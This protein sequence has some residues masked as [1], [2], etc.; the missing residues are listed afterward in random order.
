MVHPILMPKPGQMTEECTLV[1]WHKQVGDEVHKG[2]ILFEIETDK[3]NM[4]VEAFD[5]GILLRIDV[6]AGETV[7]VNTVCA[8]VGGPGESLPELAD[9]A[10]AAVAEVPATPGVAERPERPARPAPSTAAATRGSLAAAPS[11]RS[12]SPRASRIAA[13]AGID[14][15]TVTGSGPDG[16]IVERDVQAAIDA[17]EASRAAEVSRAAQ[18]PSPGPAVPNAADADDVSQTDD[19][20]PTDDV[21]Q[22]DDVPTP[23]SRMRQ[24]I[25]ER[26]TRS[27]TTIPHFSMTVGV[28]MT[29]LL[30]LRQDLK[31]AGTSLSITDFILM[32]TA[33]TLAEF[34]EANSR[35][36]GTSVWLRRRVHLGLAVSIPNGLVVPVLRDADRLTLHE[37]HDRAAG[38]A[39]AARNG[40]LSP[41]EM[42]GGTFTISNLGMLGVD[43]FEAII[44]PGEAAI[45]AVSSVLSTPVA[46]GDGI[47]LRQIMK[48]TLSADHRL[49]DGELAA[50]F[51]N[52]LR[53]RLQDVEA[54]RGEALQG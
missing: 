46:F 3:S 31:Q 50:R 30:A 47:A 48:L 52:A 32:A 39:E 49:I 10:P 54:M 37:L 2:D 29:R 7:P 40:T 38:L 45:L 4:D 23:L 21:P 43:Q 8:Y 17:A 1:S 12:I 22:T 5:D 28:D 9:R 24:V 11:G 42:R 13:M 35:T 15:R 34:P 6:R 33:Q 18:A 16:R 20:P 14:P 41:D 25:A 53:R 36:D 19:G 44:N 26:L 27:A 51:L